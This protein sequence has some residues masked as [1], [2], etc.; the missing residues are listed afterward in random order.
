M[1]ETD[2]RHPLNWGAEPTGEGAV[3]FRLWA[4]SGGEVRLRIA[5]DD[6]PMQDEGG[7]WRILTMPE[8]SPG[9][10]YSY[11][12]ESGMIVPD[13][14][15]RAQ[16]GDVHG[17]SLVVDPEAYRWQDAGWQTRPWEE[18]IHYEL[19]VGAFTPEGTFRA[20][21]EKLGQLADLGVTTIELMPIGQFSGRRGWGYDGVLIYA[22]HNAY[23]TPD[24]LKALVDAAHRHRLNIVLDVVYNHFGADGNYLPHYAP[25]FFHPNRR[26]PWGAAMAYEKRP[27]RDYFIDN[28]IYWIAEYHFDG[29][30][31]DAVDHIVDEDSETEFIVDLAQRLRAR[32]AGRRLH[33]TTE[34]DRNITRLH[35]RGPDGAPLLY[36]GEWNDDFHNVVHM[37]ATGEAE[38]YYRD[39]AERPWEKLARCL[40][41]GFAFQGEPSA[42]KGDSP[43]GEKSAHLP[44][45][46][47]VD[48]VQNHDQVGNRAFGERLIDL[49]PRETVETLLAMLLLSPHIPLLFMGEEWGETRPFVFFSDMPGS[50]ADS[51][52]AGRRKEFEQFAAFREAGVADIPDPIAESSFLASK[53]DWARRDGPEGR[54]WLAFLERLVALRMARIV[55]M[56]VGADGDCGHIEAAGEGVASVGWRLNGGT[57]RMAANLGADRRAVAKPAGEVLYASPGAEAMLAAEGALPAPAIIVTLEA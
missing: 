17:P 11:V 34:D 56:L 9:T 50:L 28:A 35:V 15:A 38:G 1:P 6:H 52:R 31:L 19:H 5:G 23:G 32:F 44:P 10:P 25:E 16:M 4:P 40:A 46:A 3:R 30:R 27:V 2:F 53:L 42:W 54:E 36:S 12:L 26:T 8:T 22:P 13:P 45:T 39:F 29:L 33:L 24:E 7:G 55:P 57:L 49:A 14:A 37:I 48:F 47:F 18:T 51:V 43:R 41:E 21:G 20:A